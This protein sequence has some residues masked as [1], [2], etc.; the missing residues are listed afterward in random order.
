M[1]AEFGKMHP[2]HARSQ[3]NSGEDEED[4]EEDDDD[5]DDD[6]AGDDNV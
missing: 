2:F 1:Q 6:G 5:G 3:C 4:D